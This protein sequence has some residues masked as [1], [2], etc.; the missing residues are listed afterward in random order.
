MAKQWR[1]RPSELLVIND[2]YVAWCVDEAVL[3][4]GTAVEDAVQEEYENTKGSKALKNGAA[5]N[6]L[7]RM[8]GVEEKFRD[9]IDFIKKPK[10]KG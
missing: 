5:E 10:A 6:A 2:P 9:P 7:R 3:E 4:F 1:A 8:L